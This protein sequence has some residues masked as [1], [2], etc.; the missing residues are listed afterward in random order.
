MLIPMNEDLFDCLVQMIVNI[1]SVYLFDIL[2]GC[3]VGGDG[4][5]WA[6]L[7]LPGGRFRR[8]PRGRR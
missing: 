3:H 4:P 7:P 2:A 1:F 5:G 6:R 8:R